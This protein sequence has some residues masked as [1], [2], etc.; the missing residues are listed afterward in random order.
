[1]KIHELKIHPEALEAQEL[2]FKNFELRKHDR[3]FQIGDILRLSEYEFDT[4]EYTGVSL[5]VVITY[6]LQDNI[7]GNGNIH[8]L[9]EGY[10]ILGTEHL[11]TAH[12]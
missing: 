1:M 10:S 12:P 6:I 4:C 3:E 5:L 11:K 9:Q 7:A 2:G 8:G